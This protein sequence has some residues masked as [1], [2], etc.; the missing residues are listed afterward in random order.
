MY[1]NFFI[2]D[3][4]FKDSL[5]YNVVFEVLFALLEFFS[6]IK[7]IC[8]FFAPEAEGWRG[9]SD[10]EKKEKRWHFRGEETQKE[11]RVKAGVSSGVVWAWL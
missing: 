7:C 10:Q 3:L 11:S 4:R 9:E 2:T 5:K 8:A 1:T 6:V